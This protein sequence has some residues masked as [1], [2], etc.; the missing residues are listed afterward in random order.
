M[1]RARRKDI[2]IKPNRRLDRKSSRGMIYENEE[3]RL[4]TIH[5]NAAIEQGQNDIKKLRKENEQLRREIWCLRDEYDKLEEILR[6]QKSHDGSDECE[7]RS[8]SNEASQLSNS[9]QGEEDINDDF[10][11]DVDAD[12]DDNENLCNNID[13]KDICTEEKSDEEEE[14]EDEDNDNYDDEDNRN[15][16]NEENDNENNEDF[17]NAENQDLKENKRET[18]RIEN[19]QLENS[20]QRWTEKSKDSEKINNNLDH[21]LVDFDGLS[22]VDEEEEQKKIQ[23]YEN[24]SDYRDSPNTKQ[25]HFSNP[26]FNP[27][28]FPSVFDSSPTHVKLDSPFPEANNSRLSKSPKLTVT[29]ENHQINSPDKLSPRFFAKKISTLTNSENR[30]KTMEINPIERGSN[31]RPKQIFAPLKIDSR[32]IG[33]SN[34]SSRINSSRNE[35]FTQ[36][37]LENGGNEIISNN[38]INKTNGNIFRTE[39][40]KSISLDTLL[41]DKLQN[42][43]VNNSKFSSCQNLKSEYS[44]N[45]RNDTNFPNGVIKKSEGNNNHS[46]SFKSQLDVIL[47]SPNHVQKV[48]SKNSS[49]L[50]NL[51][52][53][54]EEI[55]A[56]NQNHQL[57]NDKEYHGYQATSFEGPFP[58]TLQIPSMLPLDVDYKNIP[59]LPRNFYYP[60]EEMKFFYDSQ[61]QKV[62]AQTQ[63]LDED[64]ADDYVRIKKDSRTKSESLGKDSNRSRK[65]STKKEKKTIVDRRKRDTLKNQ[66]SISS[67]EETESQNAIISGT[68]FDNNRDNKQESRS[69]SSDI[70][71]QRKEQTH[72]VSIYFNSKKRPSLTSM[73]STRNMEN[74]RSKIIPQKDHS[75]GNAT[76]LGETTNSVNSKE[77][78]NNKR[79]KTS[80]SSENVPW[81]ACWGNGCI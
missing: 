10:F 73:K 75:D 78:G 5:I 17:V 23:K 45:L 40:R 68:N 48:S 62:S 50:N 52:F 65:K 58:I 47:K 71:S 15:D 36:Q 57:V 21:L 11:D 42:F 25:N 44:E 33:F 69:S 2:S 22:I 32:R 70:D 27:F 6:K 43:T 1:L 59:F 8:E 41:L 60:S 80:T 24:N 79:R 63:T 76:N 28:I 29:F 77:I 30:G 4:R 46:K 13:D 3:L 67:C 61:P 74:S 81:C 12:N 66:V 64:I 37:S 9:E 18:R 16:D 35:I 53:Q 19:V 14:E 7:S 55:T 72:R 20:D 54:N 26:I 56:F 51:F 38:L 49:S 39:K 31:S 34:E